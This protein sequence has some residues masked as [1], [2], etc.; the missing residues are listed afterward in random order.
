[1]PNNRILMLTPYLPYPPVSG[2]R[3]RTYNLV[4]RLHRDFE[5]TILCFGRPEEQAFDL[6]P[7]RVS[8]QLAE[9]NDLAEIADLASKARRPLIWIGGGGRDDLRAHLGREGRGRFEE[10]PRGRN[11]H[12]E[13]R[14]HKHRL[15]DPSSRFACAWRRARTGRWGRNRI[16]DLDARP[17]RHGDRQAGS[18]SGIDPRIVDVA[19]RLRL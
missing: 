4:K 7:L 19:A 5:I 1:M 2:G 10:V 12:G 3:S 6:K 8:P 15:N 16:L 17:V 11:R 14:G 9:D 18:R 13:Q